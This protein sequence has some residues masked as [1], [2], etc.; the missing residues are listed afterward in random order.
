MKIEEINRMVMTK[1]NDIT[2]YKSAEFLTF[3]F[4]LSLFKDTAFHLFTHQRQ[5]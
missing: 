4:Q 1:M 3:G 2:L 5:I